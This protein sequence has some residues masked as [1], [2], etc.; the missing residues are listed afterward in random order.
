VN[1]FSPLINQ[2]PKIVEQ[3][4]EIEAWCKYM[5]DWA[6][7]SFARLRPLVKQGKRLSKED[8][9]KLWKIHKSAS[10]FKSKGE[11]PESKEYKPKPKP[12]KE[13]YV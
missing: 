9:E 7:W 10:Y 1:P 4:R 12:L 2:D 11:I 13:F 3:M 5:P 8:E 6:L